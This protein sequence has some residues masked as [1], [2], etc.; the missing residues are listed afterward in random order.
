MGACHRLPGTRH[1]GARGALHLTQGGSGP[2]GQTGQGAL[3]QQCDFFLET[4][5]AL[6]E[7]YPLIPVE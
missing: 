1:R 5:R 4:G 7:T 6:S 2:S 3:L